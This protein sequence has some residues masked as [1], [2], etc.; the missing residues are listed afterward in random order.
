[1]GD[2]GLQITIGIIIAYGSCNIYVIIINNIIVY[3]MILLAAITKRTQMP[4]SSWLPM[5]IAVP[6]PISLLVHFSTL[7]TAGFT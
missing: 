1:V 5:A 4:F 6:T 7:V 2:L 3:I